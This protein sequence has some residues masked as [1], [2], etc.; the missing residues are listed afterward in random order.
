MHTSTP[1]S[2]TS[3]VTQSNILLKR[4]RRNPGAIAGAIVLLLIFLSTILVIFSPYD[5]HEVHIKDRLLSPS[6]K[7]PMGTDAVGRDQ[8][9]RILYGGRT[10]LTVSFLAVFVSLSIGVTIGSLAGYFGGWVDNILMRI[11]DVV[12]ILPT[13]MVLILVTAVLRQT[14]NRF[15]NN[16]Q[17]IAIALMIGTF[18][19]TTIF[20]VI[21]T[22]FVGKRGIDADR[23]IS[24]LG[25]QVTMHAVIS[26]GIRTIIIEA[27]FGIGYALIEEAGLSFLGIGIQPP[28]PSWGEMLN[29]AQIFLLRYPWMTIF[30][31]LMII[32][33]IISI[34][35]I[36]DGL[37]DMFDLQ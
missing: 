13:F 4:F 18:S 12:L 17:V 16:N 2:P 37:R 32:L 10:S 3:D 5:P 22:V 29:G 20:R 23:T 24:K 11:R 8:L 26:S 1:E 28:V 6:L 31:A 35:Y 9:T 19:W 21:R 36:G 33:V 27:I 25:R 15:I 7:H 30:P 34:N 14:Y